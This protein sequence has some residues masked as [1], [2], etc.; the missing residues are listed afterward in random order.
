[1]DIVFEDMYGITE[2]DRMAV[3][4]GIDWLDE[5]YPGWERR[6]DTS[7]LKM[8]NCERC[9]IGQ[10]V[11]DMSY[12]S[13]I[14]YASGSFGDYSIQWAI[15]HGFD[16]DLDDIPEDERMDASGINYG[17]EAQKRYIA[18]EVLWTEEVRNRLG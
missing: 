11:N 15:D 12:W 5:N 2:E 8:E 13:T 3:K 1:M 14:E 6:I 10:A 16:V 18:L 9:V 17:P 4:Q 7:Q